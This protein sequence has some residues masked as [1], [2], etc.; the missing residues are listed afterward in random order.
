MKYLYLI[1]ILLLVLILILIL[2]KNDII[3]ER[4]ENKKIIIHKIQLN[5]KLTD[6]F[7][8][9]FGDILKGTVS[10][11]KISKQFNYNFYLDL[12]EHPI[13]KY[14]TQTIPNNL[15]KLNNHIHEYF[16][17]S[18]IFNHNNLINNVNEIMKNNDIGLFETN[19]ESYIVKEL[20]ENDKKALQNIIKPNNYLEN[21]L[22]EIK[23]NFNL[24]NYSILH[25]RTGD[26]N[27]NKSLQST[28]ISSVEKILS[29]IKLPENILLLSDSHELKE[30]LSKKYKYKI[31]NSEIIHLGYLNSN[32]KDIGI[33]STLIDFYL[34]CGSNKIYTLSVYDWNSGFSKMASIIYNVP[35]ENYKI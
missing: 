29:K 21:K 3:N 26:D 23:S 35:I 31:I 1:L 14:I 25:I 12:T 19:C 9:G 28:I 13:G 7:P 20:S 8:P 34:I 30:Y 24:N 15:I 18:N 32:N 22:N 27:I 33:E 11:Y 16:F 17:N 4:F 10:L 2:I 5:P 6:A